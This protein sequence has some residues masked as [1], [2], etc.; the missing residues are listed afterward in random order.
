MAQHEILAAGFGGQGVMSLGMLIAYSAM[1][2][3]R[4][5]SWMPSYGPEMRGGTANCSV[6]VSDHPIGS[7]V[8]I[9]PDTLIVMNRPSLDKFEPTVKPGGLIVLNS[10]LVKTTSQRDD[11]RT[12][13]V[14]ANAMA[15]Q[16]GNS[17]MA[18]MIIT[19]AIVALTG[20]V[21]L[22]TVKAS[23]KKVFAAR[24]H[25]LLPLNEKALDTGATFVQQG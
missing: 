5:T 18:N 22:D 11:V 20:V 3:G 1:A 21:G 13:E 23:L 17:R 15:E 7:P 2:E 24:H 25:H 14:P 8:V 9:E 19:G 16:L 6:V 10:S 4:R 12:V